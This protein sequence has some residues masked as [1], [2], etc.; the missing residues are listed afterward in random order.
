MFSPPPPGRPWWRT[1]AALIGA[2]AAV[3]AIAVVLVIALSGGKSKK[4]PHIDS[5]AVALKLARRI[6]L[7]PADWGAGF[8]WDDPYE[9]DDLTEGLADSSC[10]Y[11]MQPIVDALAAVQ[12]SVHATDQ[13]VNAN[14][15][16]V[17][18]REPSFAQ[19]D[20]ARFRVSTQRCRIVNGAEDKARWEGVHE[21]NISGL[22][23]FDEVVAE[24][25]HKVADETGSK[26]DTYYTY[27]TGRKGQFLMQSYVARSGAQGQNRN[28]AVNALSLMLSRL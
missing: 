13:T 12:R 3:V 8:V 16:L 10:K 22:R 1:R 11:A 17:V 9:N 4:N 6:T 24:E 15:V 7:T 26:A 27:L 18:Y 2:A 25:G 5:S 19:A 20:A 23:G 21:V 28:D 14:S